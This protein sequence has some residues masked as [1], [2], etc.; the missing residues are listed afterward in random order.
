M[1]ESTQ[2]VD[3]NNHD[4][5]RVTNYFYNGRDQLVYMVNPADD[6]GQVTYS[7]NYYDN[8]GRVVMRQT[9]YD[10][11]ENLL[12][13]FNPETTDV[14]GHLGEDS[15]AGIVYGND[16]LLS[17]VTTDYDNRGQVYRTTTYAVNP[18]DG[19]LVDNAPLNDPDN[20]ADSLA[21]NTWYDAAGRVIK[22][23]PAGSQTFTK[24]EY[25]GLGRVKVQYVGYDVDGESTSNL[26]DIDGNVTL[27]LTDDIILAQ[28]EYAYDDSGLLLFV[29]TRQ[30]SA[31]R[32]K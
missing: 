24:F 17:C 5:D 31:R 12:D 27:N 6:Q 28:T 29:T 22:Q 14:S 1:E 11:N 8:L 9:Y 4:Y 16:R 32:G 2:Y 10:A 20:T 26:Y 7:M 19:H 23:Q 21:A 3:S 30:R 15:L 25:D 18:D 13:P